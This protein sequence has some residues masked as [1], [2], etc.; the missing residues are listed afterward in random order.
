MHAADAT[1]Y[2]FNFY[3]IVSFLQTVTCSVHMTSTLTCLWWYF[4]GDMGNTDSNHLKCVG[5]WQGWV[6]LIPL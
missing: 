2:F 3:E 4:D 5:E 6:F 1:Y